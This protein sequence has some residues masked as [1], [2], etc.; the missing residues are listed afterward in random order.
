MESAGE[1][2]SIAIDSIIPLEDAGLEDCSLPPDSIREAFWKAASAVRSIVSDEGGCVEDPWEESSYEGC[3]VEKGGGWTEAA[4]DRVVVVGD[5]EEKVDDYVIWDI[6]GVQTVV[7]WRRAVEE[8]ARPRR[9]RWRGRG[10]EDGGEV[11]KGGGFSVH[12]KLEDP[13]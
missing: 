9:R 3:V 8:T 4:G 12:S 13:L 7:S 1:T 11:V 10:G 2:K 6:V 5:A